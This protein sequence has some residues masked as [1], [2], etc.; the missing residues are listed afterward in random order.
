MSRCSTAPLGVVDG[1]L[2]VGRRLVLGGLADEAL[3]AV[4]EGDP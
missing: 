3:A 2:W 1:A 4:G